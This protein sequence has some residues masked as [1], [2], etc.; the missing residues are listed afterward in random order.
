MTTTDLTEH[1]SVRTAKRI[2]ED[3]E[4]ALKCVN[5][6]FNSLS[7]FDQ[8][9]PVRNILNCIRENETLMNIYLLRY[10]NELRK[11]EG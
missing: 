2:V 7:R 10:R 1:K 6:L 4:V 9:V 5:V 8:Y 11:H 3:L